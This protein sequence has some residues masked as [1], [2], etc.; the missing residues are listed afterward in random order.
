MAEELKKLFEE[1]GY[2][3]FIDS[4]TNQQFMILE[5]SDMERLKEQVTFGFWEHL[6]ADHTVV[7]FASS[8]STSEED[9]QTL[10]QALD[11]IRN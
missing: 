2:S 1:R 8:W 6:D 3:F 9:L 11:S 5:N 7:R 10:A 4:P